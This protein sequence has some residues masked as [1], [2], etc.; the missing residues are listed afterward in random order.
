MVDSNSDHSSDFILEP[1]TRRELEI[2]PLLAEHLSNNEIAQKLTLAPS[3]IKWYTKQ[4][5]AKLGSIP[6][7]R[8]LNGP[9]NWGF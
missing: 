2:L 3:S 5:F 8:W 4:I 6:A 1:L 9:G 7:R